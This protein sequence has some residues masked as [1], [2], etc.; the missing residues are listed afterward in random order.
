MVERWWFLFSCKSLTC[1]VLMWMCDIHNSPQCLWCA[2]NLDSSLANTPTVNMSRT[3]RLLKGLFYCGG[4]QTTAF[5]HSSWLV[6]HNSLKI[7]GCTIKCYFLLLLKGKP[8]C[9]VKTESC[10]RLFWSSIPVENHSIFVKRSWK[11][12][13]IYSSICTNSSMEANSFFL[14]WGFIYIFTQR[15]HDGR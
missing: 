13:V 4:F 12:P 14:S 10:Y 9:C 5:T 1:S 2:L 3:Q 7:L 11:I 6:G 15:K 8:W